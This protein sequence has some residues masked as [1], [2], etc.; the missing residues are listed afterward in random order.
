MAD[1]ARTKKECKEFFDEEAVLLKKAKKM[2]Q[3]IRDSEHMIAFTGAGISTS[4]GIPDFR[5]GTNTVLKTGAGKWEIEAHNKN[6]AKT[7][8]AKLTSRASADAMKTAFPTY[9][10]MA[11]KALI[12]HGYLKHLV[13]QNTDGLHIR[14]GVPKR[15]FS[16][17]HGNRNLERCKKCKM[18]FLR[19]YRTRTAQKVHCHD[20]GRS[21]ESCGGD[22]LDTIVNFGEDLPDHEIDTAFLN[23]KKAD[24]C[25]A[26]GSSLTVTP[27]AD[28]PRD[29]GVKKHGNLVIVNLQKTPLDDIAS[30]RLNGFTDKVMGMIMNELGIEVSPWKLTRGVQIELANG[31]KSG[32]DAA[33][34]LSAGDQLVSSRGEVLRIA[35]SK[36]NSSGEKKSSVTSSSKARVSGSSRTPRATGKTPRSSNLT[37]NVL[38]GGRKEPTLKITGFNPDN[39]QP[40]HLFKSV[41]VDEKLLGE[42]RNKSEIRAGTSNLV[43]YDFPVK[44]AVFDE[45]A[46][47]SLGKVKLSFMGH[48]KEPELDIPLD[49]KKLSENGKQFFV[50]RLNFKT[51]QWEVEETEGRNVGTYHPVAAREIENAT[52]LAS[53]TRKDASSSSKHAKPDAAEPFLGKYLPTAMVGEKDA[54]IFNSIFNLALSE[55]SSL[56]AD[57]KGLAGVPEKA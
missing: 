13:S 38:R 6:A 9:T 20:T 2:A 40:H 3:L 11:L 32:K 37:A 1:T 48:Y 35:S 47:G 33:A 27:A 19:D 41:Q 43:K 49:R 14:S 24:L 50:I 36:E 45:D 46:K 30:F 52:L 10:H 56:G 31:K 39:G 34:D 18:E 26:L 12:E 53:A 22:L 54:A 5:S 4:A 28:V 16:E 21:C 15:N 8:G 44:Q 51:M 29:V 42:G 55:V 23:A 17:L 57:Y 25:L 7:G